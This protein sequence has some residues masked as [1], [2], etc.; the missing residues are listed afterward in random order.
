MKKMLII[1]GML[2]VLGGCATMPQ[3]TTQLNAKDET[4][5]IWNVNVQKG[6]ANMATVTVKKDGSVTVYN[7]SR[8]Y[9][10]R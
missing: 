8:W 1:A 2:V 3:P 10:R 4:Y 9:R 6:H 7:P 5:T